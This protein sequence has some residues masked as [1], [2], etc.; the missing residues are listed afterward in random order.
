MTREKTRE[1]LDEQID[2]RHSSGGPDE[3]DWNPEDVPEEGIVIASED[4]EG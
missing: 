1:E 2:R 3:D 4:G